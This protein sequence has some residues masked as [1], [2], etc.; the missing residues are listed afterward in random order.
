MN[1]LYNPKDKNVR[2][3]DWGICA[4]YTDGV[5][6]EGVKDR[7]LMFNRPIVNFLFDHHFTRAVFKET[8]QDHGDI[9]TY[10]KSQV[11]DL[12]TYI[13]RSYLEPDFKGIKLN[14]RK[15]LAPPP[16]TF[17]L[18]MPHYYIIAD[19]FKAA[20]KNKLIREAYPEL[21]SMNEAEIMSHIIRSCLVPVMVEFLDLKTLTIDTLKLFN[22]S[23]KT[24]VDIYGALTSYMTYISRFNDKLVTFKKLDNVEKFQ[25]HI[26]NIAMK[27]MF[28]PDVGL[29]PYNVPELLNELQN[30]DRVLLGEPLRKK[31]SKAPSPV[32]PAPSPVKPASSPVKVKKTIKVKRKRCE[33]G[34]VRNK[35]TGECEPKNPV[36]TLKKSDSPKSVKETKRRKRC[37]NGQTRDKKTGECVPK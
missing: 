17:I 6:T 2:L 21:S 14:P 37:P 27:Y 18:N 3:I 33:N 19:F 23:Y 36:K 15:M 10:S 25:L 28:S 20:F 13:F 31:S 24:N 16:Q 1:M 26:F 34:T 35:L 4:K 32:K 8:L 7:N 22:T 9:S 29:K 5:V 30:L 12:L 11:T